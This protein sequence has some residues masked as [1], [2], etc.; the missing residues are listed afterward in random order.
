MKSVKS[1]EARIS[2]L[3]NAIVYLVAVQAV[4]EEAPRDVMLSFY[5]EIFEMATKRHIASQPGCE[6]EVSGKA[7]SSTHILYERVRAFLMD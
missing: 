7:L 3:E 4:N 2:V 5:R 1:L 6:K